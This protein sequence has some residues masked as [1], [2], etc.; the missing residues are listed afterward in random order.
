MPGSCWST[1]SES[2]PASGT[3]EVIEWLLRSAGRGLA[4]KGL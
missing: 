1:G 2:A 4:P 3:Q